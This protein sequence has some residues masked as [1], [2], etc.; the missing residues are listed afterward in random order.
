MN[1]A[2]AP[3]TFEQLYLDNLNEKL[4]LLTAA[5]VDNRATTIEDYRWMSGQVR[6]LTVALNL[7]ED[8]LQQMQ[9]D[10]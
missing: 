5:L 1:M 9:R 8:L 2:H 7:F 3:K 10:E 4:Q 6:G